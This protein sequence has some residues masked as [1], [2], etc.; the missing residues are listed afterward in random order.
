MEKLVGLDFAK[1]K[2]YDKESLRWAMQRGETST[3][4]EHRGKGLPKIQ[5]IVERFPGGSLLIISR[6]AVYRYE[7]GKVSC[8]TM[9]LPLLGTYVE[10]SAEFPEVAPGDQ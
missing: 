5:E 4:D 2:S 7:N 3:R 10:I 1:S 6:T 8:E 9:E